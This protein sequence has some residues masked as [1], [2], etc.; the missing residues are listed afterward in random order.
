[1]PCLHRGGWLVAV[2]QSTAAASAAPGWDSINHHPYLQLY[3]SHWRHW[4]WIPL[5]IRLWWAWLRLLAGW[6]LRRLMGSFRWWKAKGCRDNGKSSSSSFLFV[7]WWGEYLYLA[8][9]QL[10]SHVCFYYRQAARSE[11][12]FAGWI[13]LLVAVWIADDCQFQCSS[14]EVDADDGDWRITMQ[15]SYL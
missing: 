9:Q 13:Q 7:V 8:Y 6:L 10:F 4:L 15:L 14:R 1:M 5:V 11:F 12:N 3:F 2:R